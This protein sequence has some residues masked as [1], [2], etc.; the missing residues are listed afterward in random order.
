MPSY[1]AYGLRINSELHLPELLIG[2]AVD[3][4]VTIRLGDVRSPEASAIDA[5]DYVRIEESDAYCR[6]S[7]VG[8]KEKK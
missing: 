8:K 6:W 4:D 1:R 2:P 7:R 5:D 3:A